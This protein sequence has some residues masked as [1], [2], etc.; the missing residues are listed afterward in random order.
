MAAQPLKLLDERFRDAQQ[1]IIATRMRT[2]EMASIAPE[3]DK[4][5]FYAAEVAGG[6]SFDVAIRFLNEDPWE[7][8]RILRKLMPHTPLQMHFRGQNLVGYRNYADDVVT[9]FVRHAADQG[10]DVFRVFDALND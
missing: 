8:I 3:I 9:A 5:G 2:E 10:I 6:A 4:V 7:R 1:S